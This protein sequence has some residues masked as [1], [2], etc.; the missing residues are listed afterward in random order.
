M[1]L[2]HIVEPQR[3]KGG[4]KFSPFL[5]QPWKINEFHVLPEEDPWSHPCSGG[6]ST[7]EALEFHL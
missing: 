7:L 2:D 1:P 5:S 3:L 4:R 6:D